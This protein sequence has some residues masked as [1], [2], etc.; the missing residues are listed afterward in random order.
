MTKAATTA[1]AAASA[2]ADQEVSQEQL[3]AAA[4]ERKAQADARDAVKPKYYKTVHGGVMI[5]PETQIEF[6][7]ENA[8]KSKMTGWLEFQIASKKIAEDE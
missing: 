2:A 5:D 6:N 4:A 1:A 7:G 8:V 3:D